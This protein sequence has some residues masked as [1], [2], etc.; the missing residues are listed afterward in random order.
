MRLPVVIEHTGYGKS[1][2]YHLISEG[3]LA[4]PV[5]ISACAVALVER[6]IA[7]LV[8]EDN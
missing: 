4:T 7:A 6:I 1:W 3:L 5:K 2:I 8:R